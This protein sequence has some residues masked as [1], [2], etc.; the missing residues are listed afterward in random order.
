MRLL[1]YTPLGQGA[2]ERLYQML[3]TL[4]PENDVEVYRTIE[5]LSRRLRQP[6][7]DLPIAVLHAARREDLWDILA[8]RDLLRDIRIILVLPDRDE[9][10]IAQGHILRPRFLCYT[11]SDFATVSAVLEKYL[12]RD[13]AKV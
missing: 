8:I 11:D 10:T 9:N 2:G 7:D 4:I 13:A 5:S 6:A 12:G 1:L 3:R